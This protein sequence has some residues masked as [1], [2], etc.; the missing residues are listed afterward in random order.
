[1]YV[2]IAMKICIASYGEEKAKLLD[3][4]EN[5]ITT[6]AQNRMG[7]S[8]NFYNPYYCVKE[9]FTKEEICKMT[10]DEIS[11]LLK[12]AANIGSALY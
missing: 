10:E 11:Y 5:P 6:T 4:I 7:S 12:L 2:R 1:M 8:E 9:T 3:Y